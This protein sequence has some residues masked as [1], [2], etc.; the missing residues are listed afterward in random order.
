MDAS[1]AFAARPHEGDGAT[2][3]VPVVDGVALTDRIHDFEREHGMETRAVSYGGLIPAYFKFGPA[4]HHYLTTHEV[5]ISRK[6]KI[7]VLGCE[8]GEW[9]CWPLL[10]RVI[11][12]KTTVT[13][14]DFEQPYRPDRDYSSFGPFVFSRSAYESAI[15]A[16]A[17]VWSSESSEHKT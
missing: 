9:G 7:P 10:A 1:I 8:C 14:T 3:V 12:E 13:W 16:I 11:L 2:E 6:G 15:A 5:F 4:S 17:D